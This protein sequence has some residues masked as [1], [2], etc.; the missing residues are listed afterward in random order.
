MP[1]LHVVSDD[2]LAGITPPPAAFPVKLIVQWCVGLVAA[3]ALG[4][5]LVWWGAVV[6][7]TFTLEEVRSA[8]QRVMPETVERCIDTVTIQ[9]GG[10][11]R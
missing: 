2:A 1:N 8:C 5:W 4:T 3:F 11:R 7:R 6:Q 9:R 10:A